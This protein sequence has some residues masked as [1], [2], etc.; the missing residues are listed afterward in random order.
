MNG[1]LDIPKIQALLKERDANAA[2]LTDI[3]EQYETLKETAILAGIPLTGPE[4]NLIVRAF[5]VRTKR[6]ELRKEDI[7]LNTEIKAA[8]GGGSVKLNKLAVWFLLVKLQD[9]ADLLKPEDAAYD[10]LHDLFDWAEEK[11]TSQVK[12]HDFWETL[13]DELVLD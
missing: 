3:A 9:V 13:T 10:T 1:E 11:Y 8:V 5:E 6:R 2:L 12:Y 7:R 4:W